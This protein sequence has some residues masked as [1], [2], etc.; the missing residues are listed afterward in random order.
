MK[1]KLLICLAFTIGI[2]LG[3]I[4]PKSSVVHAQIRSGA[5][6]VMVTKVGRIGTLGDPGGTLHSGAAVSGTVVGFS[7][8]RDGDGDPQCYVATE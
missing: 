4:I 7:C 2:V 6:T 5:V 1:T 8:A 3:V